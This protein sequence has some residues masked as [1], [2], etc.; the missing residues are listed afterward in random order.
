M[1]DPRIYGKDDTERIVSV[2]PL[3]RQG[4]AQ[5]RIWLRDED[6]RVHYTT[7]A[8]Y[9]FFYL[10][11]HDLIKGY[12]RERYFWK[13]L[14]GDG[15]YNNLLAFRSWGDYK[16]A[17]KHLQSV[18]GAEY[19]SKIKQVYRIASPNRQYLIQSGKTLFS[20][21][22]ADDILRMQIDI[23]TYNPG[24]MPDPARHPMTVIAMSDNR[25]RKLILHTAPD[26]RVDLPYAQRCKG[27]AVMIRR[28]IDTVQKW[29]PD[30]IEM[31]NGFEFDWPFIR[32]RAEKFDIP[33]EVGREGRT[34][35][36]LRG[37]FRAAE[38]TFRYENLIVPGR[39]CIDTLYAAFD[40]DVFARDLP[41]YGLKA[42]ARYFDVAPEDR[43][44]IE[45]DKIAD[46][47]DEDPETVVRYALHD[48][49]ETRGIA[50][51]LTGAYFYTCPILPFDLQSVA[52]A[53]VGPR[54][55]SLFVRE[56][57]RQGV[58]LPRPTKY[59]GFVGG[60][61]EIYKQGVVGPIVYADVESLYPS[62]ML[63]YGVQPDTD[64][65]ELFPVFLQNLTDLRFK[66][67][68]AMRAAKEEKRE[69]DQ[70]MY[71]GMQ[72]SAKRLINGFFGYCGWVPGL[73][74]DVD[75]AAKVTNTGREIVQTLG[76]TVQNL[77]GEIV[78]MDTD[79]ILVIPPKHVV[80]PEKMNG[81]TVMD[82]EWVTGLTKV[83]PDGINIGFDGRYERMLSYKKKNYAL[84]KYS[85]EIKM[86]GSS[87][88]SRSSE[89]F[90][91]KMVET[92]IRQ[93][94]EEDYAGM[95]E[96]YLSWRRKII[97]GEVPVEDLAKK[98][99]LKS[100]LAEYEQKMKLKNH[101]RDAGYEVGKYLEETRGRPFREGT[102]VKFY[103]REGPKDHAV[104]QLAAPIDEYDDDENKRHYLKRLG[105]FVDKF[106]AFFD[107]YHFRQIFGEEDMFGFDPGPIETIVTSKERTLKMEE[108]PF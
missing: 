57:M 71:D 77:G 39:H 6:D 98:Q 75:E 40:Y 51:Q 23:E 41:S 11:D 56:Y 47:W 54:I 105:R 55:E 108:L 27:E 104:Y 29:D 92:L 106:R 91:R 80:R 36:P 70:A 64:E 19:P 1:N 4:Q 94:L 79:G 17:L 93:I 100:T 82:V 90:G 97:R 12:P 46:V 43:E 45:G 62:I 14:D 5:M 31:H 8:F 44:Y 15:I 7:E 58:A 95:H 33:M 30:V 37:F 84:L 59:G 74:S 20:G 102:I 60:F 72:N 78:E 107:E 61:T 68:D 88:V 103:I 99:T 101:N 32:T 16:E 28:M 73:F 76:Q 42:V 52:T 2:E 67:K 53:G 69:K 3:L 24:E 87:L 89:G 81:D 38:K 25:G 10:S 86:K 66:W 9:P 85:G 65:L 83:M 49:E 18:T 26:G 50:E 22:T 21:M 34:C 63:G 35:F 48:V 96:T 13:K